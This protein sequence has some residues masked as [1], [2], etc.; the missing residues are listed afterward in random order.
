MVPGLRSDLE[1]LVVLGDVAL[2]A[3]LAQ[4]DAS[5]SL[6]SLDPPDQALGPPVGSDRIV[7]P[8]GPGPGPP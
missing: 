5:L 6:R 1:R 4:G 7:A 2:H 3:A 8:I